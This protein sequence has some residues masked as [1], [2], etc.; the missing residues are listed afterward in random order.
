MDEAFA[1][2]PSTPETRDLKEE[3]RANLMARVAEL[4]ASGVASQEAAA[5]A[6]AELGDVRDLLGESGG[7]GNLGASKGSGPWGTADDPTGL[8]RTDRTADGEARRG[9]GGN[10]SAAGRRGFDY[11]FVAGQR[12]RPKPGFVV[13]VVAWSM[14]VALGLAFG[15]LAAAGLLPLPRGLQFVFL[16]V[17]A[18]GAW[19]V[20]G[21]SLS[22]ETTTNYPMPALRAAGYGLAT[23]LGSYGLGLVG[24]IVRYALPLWLVIVAALPLVA[25]VLLFVLLGVTQT[26]RHKA[27][28]REAFAR[29]PQNRFETEPE[30][31]ARFGIYAAVIW[32]VTLGIIA[33][34]VFTVGWWWAP[35]AFVGGLAAMMLLL[36]RMMFE[37]T[38]HDA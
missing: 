15:G 19:L 23:F 21:D 11:A 3:I 2:T 37:R 31:A 18:T 9:A 36:A 20:V 26:N 12:V 32:L 28:T 17:V 22:Q 4:E 14:A 1:G 27:W 16:G 5:R 34:L 29:M 13:R 6:F 10:P 7:A 25:A 38:T 24:L 35:L 8:G 33:V 30:T